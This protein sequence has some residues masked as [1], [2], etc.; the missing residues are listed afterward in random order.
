MTT[1][2]TQTR[3]ED[4]QTIKANI[5]AGLRDLQAQSD[6]TRAEL[7]QQQQKLALVQQE[8]ASKRVTQGE[9]QAEVN[10]LQA[11]LLI[12]QQEVEQAIGTS[13]EPEKKAQLAAGSGE[14]A[15]AQDELAYSQSSLETDGKSERNLHEQINALVAY[16]DALASKQQELTATYNR[17]DAEEA[18]HV[19]A[20]GLAALAEVDS[21]IAE[22]EAKLTQAREYRQNALT[23]LAA[24][25]KPWPRLAEETLSAVVG[26]QE[27]SPAILAV[28]ALLVETQ[29]TRD[30]AQRTLAQSGPD[31]LPTIQGYHQRVLDLSARIEALRQQARQRAA[32]ELLKQVQQTSTV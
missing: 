8:Q 26:A 14:L 10:R 31:I 22:L 4:L 20:Q 5:T 24:D 21:Y 11:A 7:V 9:L 19:R 25:L 12:A 30:A 13:L 2:Q 18:E 6:Q 17:F 16:L 28:K 1:T 32:R 3:G 23:R 15:Q 29:A 27:D